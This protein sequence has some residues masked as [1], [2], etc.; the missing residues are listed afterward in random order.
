MEWVDLPRINP[1][2]RNPV[3]DFGQVSGQ[4]ELSEKERKFF[5]HGWCNVCAATLN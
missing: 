1:Q 2:S 5:G 4:I 3:R